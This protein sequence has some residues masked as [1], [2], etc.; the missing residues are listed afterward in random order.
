MRHIAVLLLGLLAAAAALA[1]ADAVQ[2]F[3]DVDVEYDAKLTVA[4]R[5]SASA[6]VARTALGEPFDVTLD[7]HRVS[8]QIERVGQSEFVATLRLFEGSGSDW[9]EMTIAPIRHAG[10]FGTQSRHVIRVANVNLEMAATV[11]PL[12]PDV[13]GGSSAKSRNATYLG[14]GAVALV[15]LFLVFR[16]SAERRRTG[17][18]R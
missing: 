17:K 13:A 5:V 14:L 7:A 9:S 12:S 10:E 16:R 15:V 2:T 8:Y 18:R 6:G 11:S 4:G 1:Q 3:T